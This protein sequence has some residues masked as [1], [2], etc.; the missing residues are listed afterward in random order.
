MQKKNNNNDRKLETLSLVLIWLEWPVYDFVLVIPPPTLIKVASNT[1]PCSKLGG[2][3]LNG[4]K[5]EVSIISHRSVTSSGLKYERPILRRRVSTFFATVCSSY[6]G[7]VVR[8]HARAA[9]ETRRL[10]VTSLDTRKG[11]L[12][13]RISYLLIKCLFVAICRKIFK[14]WF[15][16]YKRKVI[17]R[18]LCRALAKKVRSLFRIVGYIY[19]SLSLKPTPLEAALSVCLREVSACSL[20][21]W[22]DF[23]RATFLAAADPRGIF[24]SGDEAAR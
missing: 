2:T 6:L 3:T 18:H 10:R 11:V 17:H 1:R 16:R 14:L 5:E 9:R 12:V 4:W 15:L 24:A 19:S 22:R 20:R 8:S 7:N 23:N 21:N 13:R